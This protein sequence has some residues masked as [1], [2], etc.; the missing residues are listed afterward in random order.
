MNN[1]EKKMVET[2]ID[3]RENHNVIGV[4]AEFEAEG[5]RMEEA[6]RLKEVITKAGLE[7]TIKIG[8]C[9]AIK[10]M[11]DSRTIGVNTIVA[12]MIESPYAVKK[13]IQA[14]KLAF[15]EDE[16][17]NIKF[18]INIETIYG[19]NYLDEIL[20]SDF[21]K[22]LAGI[23]LGRTDMT[24]SLNMSK[25]DINHDKILQFALKIAEQTL[26]YKKDFVI[27]GGVSAQSLPFFKKL[28]KNAL[29]RFET[30]KVIF[31]AQKALCDDNADK[32]ILK[33]VGFELMWIKNKRDFYGSIYI[34]DAKRIE[35]LES[36]YKKSIRDVGG[37]VEA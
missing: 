36:R 6:L 19:F 16:R 13:Y 17:T 34:E 25:D 11:Y 23:V 8:G 4:K 21:S 15:P 24:G 10:D 7:L 29:T 22:D 12:P 9:E 30:R 5:T 33:A 18:L 1:L 2:L 14:T 32:G 31:D 35:V 3:L 26:K 27:G 37:Y 20:N 28:P